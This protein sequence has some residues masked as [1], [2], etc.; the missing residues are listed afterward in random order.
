MHYES[1]TQNPL[2]W[3]NFETIPRV[4][5]QLFKPIEN[6]QGALKAVAAPAPA[7]EQFT[8]IGKQVG[9]FGY[10]TLDM[11]VWV[12]SLLSHLES[13]MLKLANSHVLSSL[14]LPTK[15]TQHK[16]L[17][18]IKFLRLPPSQA[19]RLNDTANRLWLA[20]IAFSIANSLAK[21]GRLGQDIQALKRGTNTSEKT[22]VTDE[23]DRKAQVKALAK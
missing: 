16:Q 3:C 21:I 4:V 6:L 8:A 11:F 18:A 9:Y 22:V 17:N 15:K 13:C 14:Y 12:S 1:W 2:R 23:V 5:L 7:A 19:K 10:L 20:G